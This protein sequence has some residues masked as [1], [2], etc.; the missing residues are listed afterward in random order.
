MDELYRA[1]TSEDLNE[2]KRKYADNP[3]V[4]TLIDGILQAREVEEAT[5]KIAKEFE[6]KIAKLARLPEPPEGIHNVYLRWAKVDEPI[7]GSEAMEVEV[8]QPDGSKVMEMRQPTTEVWRWVVELNKAFQVTRQ[9]ATNGVKTSKRAITVNKRNGSTLEPV[10]NFT[11]ATKACT[12]LKLPIGAD[13]AMRVL[14]RN[15]Y[16]VDQYDGTEFL[17]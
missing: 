7:Q 5:A 17:S 3:N 11:S 8:T 6:V 12:Y 13:S 1:M 15:S 9:T 10:G 14:T 4:V 2:L 16:I